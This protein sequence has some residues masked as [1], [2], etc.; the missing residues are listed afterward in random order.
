MPA[1]LAPERPSPDRRP[2][3]RRPDRSDSDRSDS[4]RSRSDQAGSTASGDPHSNDPRTGGLAGTGS[5]VPGSSGAV[6]EERTAAD[7]RALLSDGVRAG[8]PADAVDGVVPTM[9]VAPGSPEDVADLLRA[10]RGSGL[11]VVPRGAGTKLGWGNPLRSVDLA[12]DVRRLAGVLEYNPGDLVVRAEA[13][14]TLAGLR[15]RLAAEGQQLALDPP[16]PGAT[17]GG[18]VAANASGP[19]RLRYGTVRDLLIGV[20]VVLADGTV[21]HAGGKVVKNVAGYDLG[22]LF[23]GSFGTLGVIVETI[24]RL[25]PLPPA[26]RVVELPYDGAQQ[27]GEIVQCVLHSALVP[28]ALELIQPRGGMRHLVVLFEGVEP[29]VAAQADAAVALTPGGRILETAPGGLGRRPY[30]EGEIGLKISCEPAA[31]PAVLEALDEVE[32]QHGLAAAVAAHA[33]TGVVWVG[34]P[35]VSEPAAV[36]PA[37]EQLR[38]AV[39]AYDGSVVVA[40]APPAVKAGMDVWGPVGD[41]LALMRRVKERFDPESRLSPGRFVGG[42]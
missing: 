13:G 11:S 26:A 23:T 20:T 24:F 37:V 14:V 18:I 29:A 32:R 7:L 9:V 1:D 31:L 19:R 6:R 22:K 3:R 2:S 5:A 17:L 25:H 33:G 40:A 16:E 4:D 34:W 27:A 42:M 41:A 36:R 30:A 28:S 15:D 10:A 39:A 8:A 38:R 21:A 12:L 35:A